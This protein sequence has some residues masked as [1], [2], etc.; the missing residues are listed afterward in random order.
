MKLKNWKKFAVPI[1]SLKECACR[2]LSF[3]SYKTWLVIFLWVH[4]IKSRISFTILKKLYKIKTFKNIKLFKIMRLINLVI[5]KI[6]NQL[7]K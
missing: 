3:K 4:K 5:I 1:L 7:I 6:I 2:M